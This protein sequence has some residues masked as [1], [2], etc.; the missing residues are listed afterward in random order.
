MELA[1]QHDGDEFLDWLKKHKLHTYKQAL[2]DEGFEVL[3][4][5]ISLSK[6]QVDSLG[7]AIHMK[8]GHKM[9]FPLAIEEAREAAKEHKEEMK[10]RKE[11]QKREKEK[12]EREAKREEEEQEEQR[13]KEKAKQERIESQREREEELAEELAQVE[14]E[15]KLAQAKAQSRKDLQEDQRLQPDAKPTNNDSTGLGMSV[16]KAKSENKGMHLPATK[17][18]AAFI[19]HKKTHSKHGDSSSTLARSLKVR[20]CEVCVSYSNLIGHP[21]LI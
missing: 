1:E 9:V 6:E 21:I 19:S 11:Q 10:E 13:K 8:M 3:E 15:Q 20:N 16:S 18:Y 17:S 7:T 5:L 12:R 14:R 4:S 2:E